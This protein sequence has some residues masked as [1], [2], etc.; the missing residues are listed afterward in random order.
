[1]SVGIKGVCHYS[2]PFIDF[3]FNV[4]RNRVHSKFSLGLVCNNFLLR[5]NR[6]PVISCVCACICACVYACVHACVY[7][8]LCVCSCVNVC[9][10][11]YV[12]VC[13]YVLVCVCTC[14][15]PCMWKPEA[16]PECLF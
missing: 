4:S 5:E 16:S 10:H 3:F 1:M 9:I 11:V 14:A 6:V 8:C 2:W 12:L 7:M 15:C 13:I